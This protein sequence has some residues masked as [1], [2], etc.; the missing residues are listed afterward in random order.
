DRVKKIHPISLRICP[1]RTYGAVPRMCPWLE[2]VRLIRFRIP[3]TVTPSGRF[4]SFLVAN[5]IVMCLLLALGVGDEDGGGGAA[6]WGLVWPRGV[7]WTVL[8][9]VTTFH[10]PAVA[11]AGPAGTVVVWGALGRLAVC[12]TPLS[13]VGASPLGLIWTNLG[14]P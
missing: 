7:L 4:T 11:A 1:A 5:R 2:S 6:F 3:S 9:G 8:L 13:V 14:F 12:S 10:A